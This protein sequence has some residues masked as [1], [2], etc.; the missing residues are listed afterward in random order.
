M[1]YTEKQ[2]EEIL[3]RVWN[4]RVKGGGWDNRENFIKEMK[5]VNNL[6]IQDVRESKPN[7]NFCNDTGTDPLNE[8]THFVCIMCK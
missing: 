7:C 6:P 2:V 1:N 5:K 3:I 8:E 4:D